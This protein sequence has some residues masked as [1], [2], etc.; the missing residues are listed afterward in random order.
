MLL[1]L[2][3][4]CQCQIPLMQVLTSE[5]LLTLLQVYQKLE[6]QVPNHNNSSENPQKCSNSSRHKKRRSIFTRGA[7]RTMQVT[8]PPAESPLTLTASIAAIIFSAYS[9]SGHLTIL[10]SIWNFMKNL[11]DL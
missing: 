9:G 3:I 4:H 5:L 6:N 7:F 8:T 2:K 10:L 11:I 1:N